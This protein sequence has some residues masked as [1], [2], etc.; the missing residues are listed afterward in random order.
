VE[1]LLRSGGDPSIPNANGQLAAELCDDT[2]IHLLLLRDR[3]LLSASKVLR[4]FQ[5]EP[6]LE[7]SPTK[8]A[9]AAAAAGAGTRS[10]LDDAAGIRTPTKLSPSMPPINPDANSNHGHPVSQTY[11]LQAPNS[12]SVYYPSS[13]ER[14]Q[15][16]ST[17]AFHSPIHQL[18]GSNVSP[19]QPVLHQVYH[20]QTN[21][22]E[23]PNPLFAQ[24]PSSSQRAYEFEEREEEDGNDDVVYTAVGINSAKKPSKRRNGPFQDHYDSSGSSFA[25]TVTWVQDFAAHVRA[26][27]VAADPEF[28]HVVHRTQNEGDHEYYNYKSPRIPRCHSHSNY[29]EPWYSYRN[30]RVLHDLHLLPA[31]P[32]TYPR[33][34]CPHKDAHPH[35][36]CY[37]LRLLAGV[38]CSGLD[39]SVV[40]YRRCCHHDHTTIVP[41]STWIPLE[42]LS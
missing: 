8:V 26:S 36:H 7:K 15:S 14:V 2:D 3:S 34:C 30:L 4:D 29:R 10:S 41:N 5:E 32:L 31:D 17:T 11:Q 40:S 39:D 20:E 38:H 12:I 16:S 42:Y 22:S 18:H 19:G 13:Q 21:G 24:V 33:L 28:A 1:L 23:L 35:H 6:L 9:V 37:L 27:I 25:T